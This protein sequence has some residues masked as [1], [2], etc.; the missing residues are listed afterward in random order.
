M[1]GFKMRILSI[2]STNTKS[3][4]NSPAFQATLSSRAKRILTEEF[5]QEFVNA[6]E[7]DKT[8]KDLEYNMMQVEIDLKEGFDKCFI[9]TA[10]AK[11]N[12]RE[13]PYDTY[14][15]GRTSLKEK[16][17]Y[18]VLNAMGAVLNIGRKRN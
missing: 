10:E 2:N 13:T 8:F 7:R 14:S 1:R 5:G 6:V 11:G 4:N 9:M 17:E 16:V 18:F 15:E 12:T 3:K